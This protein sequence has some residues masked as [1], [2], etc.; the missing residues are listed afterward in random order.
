MVDCNSIIQIG[1]FNAHFEYKILM[2]H[3]INIVDVVNNKKDMVQIVV[4]L[5]VPC[6]YTQHSR[7]KQS[8]QMKY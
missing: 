5:F 1:L 3:L 4:S 6:L 8:M 2:V 7:V